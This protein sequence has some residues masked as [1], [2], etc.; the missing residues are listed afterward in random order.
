MITAAGNAASRFE[1]TD[2]SHAALAGEIEAA[3]PSHTFP[4]A[5]LSKVLS[6]LSQWFHEPPADTSQELRIWDTQV[7]ITVASAAEL[8]VSE[9]GCLSG[10]VLK[11]GVGM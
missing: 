8:W 7:C 10:G 2:S 4:F 6:K 11:D 5:L 3:D 1:T 9:R